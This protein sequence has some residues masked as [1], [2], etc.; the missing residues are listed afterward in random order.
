MSCRNLLRETCDFLASEN[1]RPDDVLY[2]TDG[3]KWCDWNTFANAAQDIVYDAGYGGQEIN[4]NLK[5]VGKQSWWMERREYDGSEWWI[6]M[7]PICRPNERTDALIL[8]EERIREIE[9]E[10]MLI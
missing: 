2:V 1:L 4:H 6:L 7:E 9:E 10:F 8:S 5:I 3:Y